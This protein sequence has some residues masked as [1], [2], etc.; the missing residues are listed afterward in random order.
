MNIICLKWGN[1]FSH[2]HVNRLYRMVCKNY[3]DDFTFICYTEN[4]NSIHP[5]IKIEPLPNYDLEN[6]WWKLTLFE[7]PNDD[8]NLFFDLDIVIQNDITHYKNYAEDGKIRVIRAYWKNFLY[9][10][11]GTIEGEK[12]NPKLYKNI[13]YDMDMNSSVMIWIGNC[14]WAWKEFFNNPDF[15]MIKYRGIDS[16][17]YYHFW[18]NLN[19]FPEREIYSRG[20]GIDKDINWG[21]GMIYPELGS[22]Y[23]YDPE[24][25]IC[26]VN[27]WNKKTK[28]NIPN[29]KFLIGDDAYHGLEHYW[30]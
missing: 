29:S 12:I 18:E 27:G 4:S 21:R 3:H 22:R 10:E 17:L 7:N 30:D 23:F 8:V 6:W 5:D 2:E 24:Y 28:G 15:Y 9:K 13:T 16:F 26:I 20:Y 19:W 14:T 1:K 25:N 11:T